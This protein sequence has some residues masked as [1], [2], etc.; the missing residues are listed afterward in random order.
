MLVFAPRE[1]RRDGRG[2]D[3]GGSSAEVKKRADEEEREGEAEPTRLRKQQSH[4]S[5][6]LPLHFL[7]LRT[8]RLAYTFLCTLSLASPPLLHPRLS[9]PASSTSARTKHI[10]AAT[11][12]IYMYAPA[13]RAAGQQRR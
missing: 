10:E 2:G 7:P 1:A 13:G 11:L 8:T 4:A 9:V 12:H 6:S 5:V 3:D